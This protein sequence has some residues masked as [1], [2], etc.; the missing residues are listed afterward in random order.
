MRLAESA[1]VLL[2]AVFSVF[3][4]TLAS[5]PPA[6]SNA[7]D[8][9][10]TGA[11]GWADAFGKASGLVSRL[12]LEEKSSM[13]TGSLALNIGS[14]AGCIGKLGPVERVNFTG[15]CLQ[16][17]PLAIRLADLASVFPAGVNVA[18]TWDRN[19]MRAQGVAMGKEFRGKGANVQLGYGLVV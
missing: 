15:L 19:L 7:S 3:P 13:V 14:Y 12:T 2:S 10:A 1:A 4:A 11:G 8:V 16:D 6:A 9:F 17:G 5:S 18:S